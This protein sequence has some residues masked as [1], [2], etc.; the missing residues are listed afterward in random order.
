MAD[1]SLAKLLNHFPNLGAMLVSPF[2]NCV[3]RVRKYPFRF[4]LQGVGDF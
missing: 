3:G 1:F 2:M 4:H